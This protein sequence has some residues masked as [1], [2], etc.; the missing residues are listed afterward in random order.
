MPAIEIKNASKSYLIKHK[1]SKS[2][3]L[4]EDIVNFSKSV[5]SK[6]NPSE[7]ELFWALKNINLTVERGDRLGVIG[8]NGAGKSTLLKILSRVT[9]PTTGE[10]RIQG[11]M[12]SL[13]EV[14]T[15]FH[16]ELTG[17]ENIYLNGSIL[18]MKN[19]EIYAQFDAIVEFAGIEQFLDTPV[20]RYS[21]GMYVRLGFA[22]AAHLEPEIL[23]VDEVLAVGDADFQKKSIG[24][25]RDVSKSGRT[26]LFVSHNLTAVQNLCNKGAFLRKGELI[27]SGEINSVINNYVQNVA[28]FQIKQEWEDQS[29]A[30]GDNGILAKRIELKS[31]EELESGTQLTTATPLKVEY[32]FWNDH[33]DVKLNVSIFLYTMTGQCIFNIANEGKIYKKGL[34]ATEFNIPGN[35]LNDGSYFIS[36]MVV[37]DESKP[38]FF[39]E[40]AL[41]FDI[42]DF[43]EDIEWV[44][45]WPGAIRPLNLKLKTWQ[46]EFNK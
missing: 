28:S 17:R 26:I 43:R 8:S 38:L 21:S 13:L 10:I 14:G 5:F 41:M 27:D 6:K 45:K 15:G 19:H 37:Q 12:A 22:I 4:R 35:F 31:S 11:R 2:N 39:F 42:Q 24:K 44:G 16:P 25:M 40:E 34:I 29:K 3:T 46:K 9:A 30:P 33:D 7:K 20:K 1:L 32:E 23:I 18:G 36:M